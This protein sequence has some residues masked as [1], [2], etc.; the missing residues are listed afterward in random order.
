VTTPLHRVLH[1]RTGSIVSSC[2]TAAPD[3]LGVYALRRPLEVHAD[4]GRLGPW[5]WTNQHQITI[6]C[7]DGSGQV[8]YRTT[9]ENP[10]WIS[11]LPGR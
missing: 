1:F 7:Q 3:W 5:G 11:W 6:T 8:L 10:G 4:G 9:H 2:T